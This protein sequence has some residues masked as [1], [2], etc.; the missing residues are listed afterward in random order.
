LPGIG[1]LLGNKGVGGLLQKILPGQ[2][3]T[4]QPQ[5]QQPGTGEPPPPPPP[6]EKKFRP[7]DLLK[8]LFKR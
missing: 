4:Q 5:Q 1:K 7:E 2:Q 8:K 3:S 6:Q